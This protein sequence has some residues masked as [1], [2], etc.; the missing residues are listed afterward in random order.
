MNINGYFYGE[1]I[2]GLIN[3]LERLELIELVQQFGFGKGSQLYWLHRFR[4][5]PEN[6]NK[7]RRQIKMELVEILRIPKLSKSTFDKTFAK[8]AKVQSKLMSR[9]IEDRLNIVVKNY[10]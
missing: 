1:N 2:M 4:N 3:N 8:Y 6:Q 5:L 9:E 10:D 7:S